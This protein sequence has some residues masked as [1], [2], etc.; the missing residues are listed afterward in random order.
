MIKLLKDEEINKF[1]VQINGKKRAILNIKKGFE[2]E[3][4]LGYKKRQNII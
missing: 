2:Q 3:D 1:V 4:L